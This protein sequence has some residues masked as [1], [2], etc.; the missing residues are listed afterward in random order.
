[1]RTQFSVPNEFAAFCR[2]AGLSHHASS[3]KNRYSYRPGLR[4]TLK[5]HTP[6]GPFCIGPAL[7]SQL[8]KS[9]ARDTCRA[10]GAGKANRVVRLT[11]VRFLSSNICFFICMFIF[12]CGLV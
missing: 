4:A 11:F 2:A 7:V 8:L 3:A 12:V 6:S 5:Y 10:V 1:M 9:P